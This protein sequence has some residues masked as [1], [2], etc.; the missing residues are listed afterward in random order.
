MT[1]LIFRE[2]KKKR[3]KLRSFRVETDWSWSAKQTE[4]TIFNSE[5]S[6]IQLPK[7]LD[8]HASRKGSFI[9]LPK[10]LDHHASRKGISISS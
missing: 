9:Q 3:C 10:W 6:F 2:R 7:W 5:F 8:H 4:E 1:H